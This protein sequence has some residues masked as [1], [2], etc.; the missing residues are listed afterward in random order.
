[1]IV[2][3]IC[4]FII[5]MISSITVAARESSAPVGSSAKMSF[6]SHTMAR[7]AATRCFWPPDIW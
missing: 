5:S 6:G 3:P 2:A 1:M 7:A 4:V